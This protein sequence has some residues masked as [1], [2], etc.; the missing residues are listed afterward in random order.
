MINT[1]SATM[2]AAA[3]AVLAV[4]ILPACSSARC[5]ETIATV[6]VDEVGPQGF[7]ARETIDA[8]EGPWQCVLTW[9]GAGSVADVS[10]DGGSTE[11]VVELRYDGGDV[12]HIGSV[13]EG[14]AP[15]ERL[16]CLSSIEIDMAVVVTTRDGALGE[17]GSAVARVFGPSDDVTV[18]LEVVDFAGSYQ[19][20]SLEDWARQG[21][22]FVASFSRGRASGFLREWTADE[23][24][25]HGTTATVAEYRCDER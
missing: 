8:V 13:R 10:P 11:A 22:T 5:V 12:R 4:L 17:E 6:S 7:S 15:G 24:G 23:S 16:G 21:T 3:L 25:S 1:A 9:N 19:Y 20:Q 2:R 14:G 18:E